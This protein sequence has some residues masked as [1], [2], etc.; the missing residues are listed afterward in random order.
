MS[1][2]WGCAFDELSRNALGFL[3]HDTDSPLGQWFGKRSRP[4]GLQRAGS[5]ENRLRSFADLP[6]VYLRLP[7]DTIEFA[8][9]TEGPSRRRR[10]HPDGDNVLRRDLGGARALRKGVAGAHS[11][12]LH[13]TF[14][15]E[16]YIVPFDADI[17]TKRGA[18][19]LLRL[20]GLGASRRGARLAIPG[21]GVDTRALDVPGEVEVKVPRG[22]KPGRY[23]CTLPRLLTTIVIRIHP[24]AGFRS[25]VIDFPSTVAYASRNGISSWQQEGGSSLWS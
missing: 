23:V 3:I 13:F 24:R 25:P 6:E 8:F 9:H 2:Q 7:V 10:V 19:C 4:G 14:Y 1:M 17:V 20:G 11:L 12:G 16:G 15:V 22:V 18:R 21:W 5:I